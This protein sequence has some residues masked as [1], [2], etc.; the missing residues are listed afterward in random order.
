MRV[1][2]VHARRLALS[3][4]IVGAFASPVSAQSQLDTSQAQAF[5]GNWVIALVTD[6]GPMTLHLNILDQGGKVAATFGS[7]DLGALQPVTDITR[8]GEELHL[9]LFVDAQG[10]SID[11]S[12]ALTPDGDGLNV[13]L[14]AAGGSFTANARATKAT[15]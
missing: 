9:S 14:A 1:A 8:S 15:S 7:P 4:V 5:L 11:V 2:S 10:Q 12:L 13:A 6:M 3:A